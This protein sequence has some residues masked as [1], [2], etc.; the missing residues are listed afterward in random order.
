MFNLGFGE[1]LILCA[2]LVVVVGPERLSQLPAMLKGV[3]KTVSRR[4]LPLGS[5][6]L[7]IL[8]LVV[9]TLMAVLIASKS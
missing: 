3:E 5:G 1:V 8:C 7:L 6:E 4:V 9:L 2:I